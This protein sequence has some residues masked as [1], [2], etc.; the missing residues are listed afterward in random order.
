MSLQRHVLMTLLSV[1]ILYQHINIFNYRKNLSSKEN[2]KLT[3][4][5]VNTNAYVAKMTEALSTK[6]NFIFF[7]LARLAL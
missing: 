3:F 5:I 1:I 2:Q 6:S 7:L 4:P